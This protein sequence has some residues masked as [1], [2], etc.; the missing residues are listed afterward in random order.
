VGWTTTGPNAP[1]LLYS[2]RC[3]ATQSVGSMSLMLVGMAGAPTRL[4]R[5]RSLFAT[6]L[7]LLFGVPHLSLAQCHFPASRRSFPLTYTFQPEV[8]AGE[9]IVH[10]RLQFRTD[11]TGT[12]T[13][14]LPVEYAGENY[15]RYQIYV[16]SQR[17]NRSPMGRTSQ[18]RHCTPMRIVQ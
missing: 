1:F 16:R 6:L 15:M 5:S 11:Q 4:L 12:A 2:L 17:T 9:L 14:V 7:C 8:T 13:L 3:P 10:V 18:P